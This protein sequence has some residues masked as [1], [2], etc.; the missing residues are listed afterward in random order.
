[1]EVG[2]GGAD[3]GRPGP[4]AETG[5]A[6]AGY[7][8]RRRT[9]P[10]RLRVQ[11]LLRREPGVLKRLEAG[12]AGVR[13]LHAQPRRAELPRPPRRPHDPETLTYRPAVT[14]L[15]GGIPRL[16]PPQPQRRLDAPPAAGAAGTA[17]ARIPPGPRPTRRPR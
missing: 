15:P 7:R 8:Q 11:R 1:G 17:G 13:G 4:A 14:D 10:A 16:P 3:G 5:G 12:S 2:P 9:V 6:C